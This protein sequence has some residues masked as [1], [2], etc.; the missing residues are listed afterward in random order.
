MHQCG[1]ILGVFW[2]TQVPTACYLVKISSL[3]FSG[4]NILTRNILD[5]WLKP[6]EY[7]VV[8][9]LFYILSKAKFF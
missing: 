8:S 5:A 6:D 7:N 1:N 2:I 9:K 4:T 3:E